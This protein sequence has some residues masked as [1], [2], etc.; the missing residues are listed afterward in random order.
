MSATEIWDTMTKA[1]EKLIK[2]IRSQNFEKFISVAHND[3]GED[4]FHEVRLRF[5]S[6]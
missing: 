3:N 6:F 4:F 5:V 2:N 1:Q